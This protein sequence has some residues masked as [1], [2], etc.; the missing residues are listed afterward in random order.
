MSQVELPGQSPVASDL[1]GLTRQGC[2]RIEQTLAL[3]RID[4]VTACKPRA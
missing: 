1:E 2:R 4:V 3:P